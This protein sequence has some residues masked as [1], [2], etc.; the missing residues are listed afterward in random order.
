VYPVGGGA[1]DS[2]SANHE[3]EDIKRNAKECNNARGTRPIVA[4]CRAIGPKAWGDVVG[5]ARLRQ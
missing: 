3:D 1:E 5:V 4:L 2:N